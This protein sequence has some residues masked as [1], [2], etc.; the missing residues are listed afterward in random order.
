MEIIRNDSNKQA[1]FCALDLGDVFEC[2]GE[3]FIKSIYNG[4]CCSLSLKSFEIVDFFGSD[5]VL[6]KNADLIIT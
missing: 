4:E 1:Y 3:L 6:L 5:I 2:D